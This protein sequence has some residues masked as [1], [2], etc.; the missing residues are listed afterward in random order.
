MYVDVATISNP[1]NLVMG[2]VCRDN[3]ESWLFGFI[4]KLGYWHITKVEFYAIYNGLLLIFYELGIPRAFDVIKLVHPSTTLP[5]I[6]QEDIIGVT[7]P[8]AII[9]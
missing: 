6:I 3:V 4:G 5:K 8:R 7:R 9:T 1:E 2:G